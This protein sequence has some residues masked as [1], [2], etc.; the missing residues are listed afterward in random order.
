MNIQMKYGVPIWREIKRNVKK[1]SQKNMAIEDITHL[2][3]VS[4]LFYP[5]TEEGKNRYGQVFFDTFHFVNELTGKKLKIDYKPRTE[6]ELFP[7]TKDIW[8]YFINK[9]EDLGDKESEEE[10]NIVLFTR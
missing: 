3:H 8:I 7:E 2:T 4:E 1:Y 9:L 6:F 10:D 5:E